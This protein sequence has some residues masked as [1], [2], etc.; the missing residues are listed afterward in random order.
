M[1]DFKFV[2]V[3][4]IVFDFTTAFIIEFTPFTPFNLF[5]P[6]TP[7]TPYPNSAFHLKII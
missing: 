6:F 2:I 5:T 4:I 7:F 1:L 3:F